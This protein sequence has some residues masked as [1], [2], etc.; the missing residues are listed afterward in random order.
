MT[1]ARTEFQS[2]IELGL[3]ER[4][5]TAAQ[6]AKN[7]LKADLAKEAASTGRTGL[8]QAGRYIKGFFTGNAGSPA[9]AKE[10]LTGAL[11]RKTISSKD[12]KNIGIG[13]GALLAGAGVYRAGG[14]GKRQHRAELM[15]SSKEVLDSI[16]EFRLKPSIT[17]HDVEQQI[18]SRKARVHREK[19]NEY[20]GA[21]GLATGAAGTIAAVPELSRFLE[22]NIS[23][24]GSSI[25]KVSALKSVG[26]KLARNPRTALLGTLAV[27]PVALGGAALAHRVAGWSNDSKANKAQKRAQAVRMERFKKLQDS[28]PAGTKFSARAELDEILFAK[29]GGDYPRHWSQKKI[30]KK[31]G[32]KEPDKEPDSDS[33]DKKTM[34][35]SARA[36]L[37]QI[38]FE[39]P[40]PRNALGMFSGGGEGGPNP[41]SMQITYQPQ[42]VQQGAQQASMAAQPQQ[43]Q[44]QQPMPPQ[45]QQQDSQQKPK[46]IVKR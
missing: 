24:A 29:K 45:P 14:S 4:L 46:K 41:Q 5:A 12:V 33:D 21:A 15:M 23:R 1:S 2:I 25:S 35:C 17:Y 28:A 39:D 30:T 42:V 10:I 19:S 6:A 3:K 27:A 34:K 32:H 18:Q 11:K 16:I 44:G 22:G 7:G 9:T 37:S 31:R 40:R 36:E 26:E 13:T 20:L 43:E 38:L 8:R